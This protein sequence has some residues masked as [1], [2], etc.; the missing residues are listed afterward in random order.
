LWNQ[1]R[2]DICGLPVVV[3]ERRDATVIGAAVAAWVGTGRFASLTEGERALPIETEVVEPSAQAPVYEGLYD[4]YRA[5]P[6]SLQDFY[7]R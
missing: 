3:T 4:R 6:P 1:L 7:S 5:I 2:A